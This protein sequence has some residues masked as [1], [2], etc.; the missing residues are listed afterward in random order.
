MNPFVL[1]YLGE[2]VDLLWDCASLCDCLLF[3]DVLDVLCIL[4]SIVTR[5]RVTGRELEISVVNQAPLSIGQKEATD[6]PMKSH[7]RT[8]SSTHRFHSAHLSVTSVTLPSLYD[9]YLYHVLD[10]FYQLADSKSIHSDSFSRVYK[11]VVSLPVS[12]E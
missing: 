1:E 8:P 12:Y 4:A 6:A 9:T 5:N 11:A 2:M 10:D 3:P 7:P